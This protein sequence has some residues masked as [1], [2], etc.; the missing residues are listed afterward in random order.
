VAAPSP[1][2]GVLETCK[3]ASTRSTRE[4]VGSEKWLLP[5]ESDHGKSWIKL[6]VSCAGRKLRKYLARD[7]ASAADADADA[8]ADAEFILFLLILLVLVRRGDSGEAPRTG[9]REARDKRLACPLLSFFRRQ[10]RQ[11]LSFPSGVG[12][13]LGKPAPRPRLTDSKSPSQRLK[14]DD[15]GVSGS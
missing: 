14:I 10:L 3:A 12:V 13:G 11:P 1:C 5:Y 6:F 7:T 9:S 2:N 8:D 4:E 15:L